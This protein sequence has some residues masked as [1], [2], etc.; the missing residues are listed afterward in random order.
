MTCVCGV[1]ASDARI[2]L[3]NTDGTDGATLNQYCPWHTRLLLNTLIPVYS[4]GR[5]A[6]RV[7][8]VTRT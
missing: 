1:A 5:P 2:T 8:R 3:V 7:D 6:Y 4:T